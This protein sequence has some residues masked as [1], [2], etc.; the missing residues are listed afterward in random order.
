[1]VNWGLIANPV[2]GASG[3]VSACGGRRRR[4]LGNTVVTAVQTT[5]TI[6]TEQTLPGRQSSPS[7]GRAVIRLSD[8]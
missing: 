6:D 2:G 7:V 1:M 8:N 3:Y 5:L 4:R